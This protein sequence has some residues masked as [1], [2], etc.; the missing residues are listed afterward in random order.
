MPIHTI[1]GRTIFA[2]QGRPHCPSKAF[3]FS[4]N[5]IARTYDFRTL[6]KHCTS[7]TQHSPLESLNEPSHS[8]THK[9]PIISLGRGQFLFPIKKQ[10]QAPTTEEHPRNHAARCPATRLRTTQGHQDYSGA[11]PTRSCVLPA[12]SHDTLASTTQLSICCDP[13]SNHTRVTTM[14]L[15]S[16]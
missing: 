9:K 6:S 1:I 16:Q 2:Q 12:Y 8:S 11:F 3:F 10:T 5:I 13:T 4:R 15:R 7:L 14:P